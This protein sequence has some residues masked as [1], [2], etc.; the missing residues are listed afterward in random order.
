MSCDK[1]YAEF[2][3]C[4]NQGLA[5]EAYKITFPVSELDVSQVTFKMYI[6]AGRAIKDTLTQGAGL[7]VNTSE[8]A[9]YIDTWTENELT[10]YSYD[11]L[12]TYTDSANNEWD[13]FRGKYN[14]Q[15]KL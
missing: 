1:D 6:S 4:V 12:I 14:V 3:I 13:L 11:F 8:N 5:N 2:N 15:P 10:V 9:L 7:T